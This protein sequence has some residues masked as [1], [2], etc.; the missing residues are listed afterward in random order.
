MATRTY[1]CTLPMNH[2]S[3]RGAQL[4]RFLE[5]YC[6]PLSLPPLRRLRTSCNEGGCKTGNNETLGALFNHTAKVN[7][8]SRL[9]SGN[10][11]GGW[12]PGTLTEH[13]DV[14]GYSHPAAGDS[15]DLDAGGPSCSTPPSQKPSFS[16]VQ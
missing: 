15:K 5:L 11:R 1:Y 10:M 12:G 16:G 8:R 7:D 3:G 9:V 2:H 6:Y 4:T 14:Q 13:I